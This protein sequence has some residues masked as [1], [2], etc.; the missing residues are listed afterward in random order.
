M[1][2]GAAKPPGAVEALL[3]QPT[4][5]S[6]VAYVVD[7]LTG[8]VMCEIPASRTCKAREL[9]RGIEEATAL[10][11]H[12]IRLIFAGRPLRP[13]DMPDLMVG[14]MPTLRLVRINPAWREALDRVQDKG[15]GLIAPGYNGHDDSYIR[16]PD[17]DE[18]LLQDHGFVL[19]AV[20]ESGSTLRLAPEELRDDK[21][22]V[23]AAVLENGSALTFAS[24][25]LRGDIEVVLRAVR[26]AG[27]ALEFATEAL[28]GDSE[29]VAAAVQE[30]GEAIQFANDGLRRDRDLALA[31]VRTSGAALRHV[32]FVLLHDIEFIR[33]AVRANGDAMQYAPE[34]LKR[35]KEVALAAKAY[36]SAD[37]GET[38]AAS[39]WVRRAAPFLQQEDE[40]RRRIAAAR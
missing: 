37:S 33:A 12:E 30:N 22:V 9:A 10:P 25:R 21:E 4:S 18:A 39:A 11:G 6:V 15:L 23:L 27:V 3:L 16:T 28:R 14:D 40:G 29:V 7:G 38:Q 5:A 13:S 8:S 24:E 20:Q 17:P 36:W 1:P 34:E 26:S 19:A 35:D 31:A 32:H 2:S